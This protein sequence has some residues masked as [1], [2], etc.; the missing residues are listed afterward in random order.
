MFPFV[1]PDVE[2][3]DSAIVNMLKTHYAKFFC[4]QCYQECYVLI[5]HNLS[6]FI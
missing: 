6:S 2:N 1:K 3:P 4:G 5:L